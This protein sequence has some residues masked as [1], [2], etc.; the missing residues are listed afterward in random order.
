MYSFIT[1]LEYGIKQESVLDNFFSQWYIIEEATHYQQS[2]GIDR[3]F[4]IGDK[5]FSVE[6]KTDRIAGRTNNSFIETISVAEDGS[7]GWAIT[8]RADVLIYFVPSEKKV[9][10]IKFNTLRNKLAYWYHKY[11]RKTVVNET[12]KGYGILVPLVELD[13]IALSIM[14]IVS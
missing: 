5:R 8:S 12:W 2:V 6:Y 10:V 4:S 3:I 1:S 13:N 7:P 11:P 9:W 14:E